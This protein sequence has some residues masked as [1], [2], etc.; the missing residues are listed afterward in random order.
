MVDAVLPI[1][2]ETNAYARGISQMD[3][4]MMIQ[5]PGGK[6]RTKPELEVLANKAGFRG[7]R[8]ECFV[9]NFW[10]MEFFKQ[11]DLYHW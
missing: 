7:I 3:V 2:P 5:V 9:C 8:Y 6:E 11:F 1:V 4:L 10:V